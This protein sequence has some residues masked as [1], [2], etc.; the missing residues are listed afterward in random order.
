M[1]YTRETPF[2]VHMPT[3]AEARRDQDAEW[4]E[5]ETSEG[6]RRVRFHDYAD[7][8][9]IP[10]FYEHLFYEELE[11]DSPRTVRRL[12]AGV[13]DDRGV[14]PAQLTVLDVG[15]GNGMM[16]EQLDELGARA[17]VGVDILEEAATAAERDRP[18]VYEDYRVMDLADPQ[19]D[20]DAALTAAG[21]NCMTSV[22]ALGFGDIPPAAFA[23][24]FNYV[25]DGGLV[26]FTIKDRF[27]RDS[28]PTGFAALLKRMDDEAVIDVIVEHRYRH[29]LS[30]SGDPLHYMV[31]VAEKT[32]DVPLG[33]AA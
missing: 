17:I 26:T 30:V 23:R 29:R 8:Y 25:E 15:A 27:T 11:C 32:R 13:L 21:F 7:I 10:G 1:S 3:G 16:G 4:C 19:P 2:I 24:A 20:E 22:A 5:L 6:R 33:W 14:D 31:Y 18:D 28:D 12:L 9:A